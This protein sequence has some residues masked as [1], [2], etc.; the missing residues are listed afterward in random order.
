MV[1]V[2]LLLPG[3]AAGGGAHVR[4]ARSSLECMRRVVDERVPAGIPD[5]RAHCLA[6]G[7]IAR[8]CSIAEAWLAS[9]GKE[10]RD[11]L[12]GGDA[13]FRDLAADAA[14][15]D[16]ARAAQT[17]EDVESCCTRRAADQ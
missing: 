5:G 15:V 3:C 9:Y 6:V 7:F 12:G 17:D 11:L 2:G 8:D 16:C 14:G 13:E 10:L 1:L 4:P